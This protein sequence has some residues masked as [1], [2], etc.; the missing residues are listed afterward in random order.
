MITYILQG[1]NREKGMG[2][3]RIELKIQTNSEKSTTDPTDFCLEI[4][5]LSASARGE[6][7]LCLYPGE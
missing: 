1:V 3:K 6:K 5:F 2:D 4:L 7:F